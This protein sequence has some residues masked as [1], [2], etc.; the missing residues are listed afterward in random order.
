M[1]NQR[2]RKLLT[3]LCVLQIAAIIALDLPDWAAIAMLIA[4]IALLGDC[5]VT[6]LKGRNAE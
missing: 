6:I 4:P 1:L 2:M 5:I 3:A